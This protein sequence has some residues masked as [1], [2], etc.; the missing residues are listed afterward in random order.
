MV[1]YRKSAFWVKTKRHEEERKKYVLTMASY[2][3][4]C[5]H[6]CQARKKQFVQFEMNRL[7]LNDWNF[8]LFQHKHTLSWQ[9]PRSQSSLRTQGPPQKTS[10]HWPIG[11]GT[12][13]QVSNP[14]GTQ[15]AAGSGTETP[16]EQSKVIVVPTGWEEVNTPPAR[17]PFTPPVKLK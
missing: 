7:C 17:M 15:V 8:N 1:A 16:L 12:Q 5:H 2:T 9:S 11:L 14:S 4:E 3:C 6:M 13:S 10:M